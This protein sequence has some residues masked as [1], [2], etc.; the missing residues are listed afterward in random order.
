[1]GQKA[2]NSF[3]SPPKANRMMCWNGSELL[4]SELESW[5]SMV[6]AYT[7]SPP[8]KVAAL[9]W[10]FG[11]GDQA[12]P[13]QGCS[14]DWAC[15]PSV[16]DRRNHPPAWSG[17]RSPVEVAKRAGG[18]VREIADPPGPPKLVPDPWDHPHPPRVRSG[19]QH[20]ARTQLGP[21]GH[22]P[23]L[24]SVALASRRAAPR[25]VPAPH[26]LAAEPQAEAPAPLRI[27]AG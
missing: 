4:W 18:L 22:R 14:L 27:A 16:R 12:N 7:K 20:L 11:L 1:M 3:Q 21:K 26:A 6:N 2:A 24:C 17:S 9:P 15:C 25:S 23:P 19:K 13:F 10:G 8:V 5:W